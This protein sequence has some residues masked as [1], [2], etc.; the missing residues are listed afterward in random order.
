MQASRCEAATTGCIR[1]NMFVLSSA[2]AAETGIAAR[3]AG[4]V[5]EEASGG[6]HG[7]PFSVLILNFGWGSC[8]KAINSEGT[9]PKLVQRLQHVNLSKFSSGLWSWCLWFC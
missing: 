2:G 7:M 8:P 3:A 4:G 5:P 1:T 6:G 9:P